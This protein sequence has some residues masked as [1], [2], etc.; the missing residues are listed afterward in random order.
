[1]RL[2]ACRSA[3][4]RATSS[5]VGIVPIVS[6]VDAPQELLVIRRGGGGNVEP[7]QFL[8][9]VTS[10]RFE[11]VPADDRIAVGGARITNERTG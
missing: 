10:M 4:K 3:Q 7:G 11:G 1:M 5:A 2:S 9:N 6:I 8:L